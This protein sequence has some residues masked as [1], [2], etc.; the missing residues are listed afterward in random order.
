[1]SRQR[2][3]HTTGWRGALKTWRRNNRERFNR[4]LARVIGSAE[5]TSTPLAEDTRRILVVRL[6][7]RLGNILFLTPMLRSL[8]ATLPAARIDV[9]IQDRAQIKLLES[10]PGIGRVWIQD[11]T[12]FGILRLLRAV[13][14]ERY[15]LAI[16]P[17]SNS[18]SNRLALALA[19]ARQ[20]MGF[21]G[22]DQWV[23]LTHASPRAGSDHQ[24]LK[25]VQLLEGAIR[26]RH[27][28]TF[29]TLAVF[30]D[31][32][33][34]E[35]AEVHWQNALGRYSSGAPVIGFFARATGR[36][37]LP[38]HWWQA[39]VAAIRDRA[40][41]AVLLEILPAAQALPIVPELPHI[42][43]RPLDELSAMLAKLDVFVAADSGPMHLAAASGV[44]VV[45]LFR[46][47]SPKAYA[48]LGRSCISIEGNKLDA[49]DVAD[50]V[51]ARLSHRGSK[52]S[53]RD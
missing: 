16:D 42:A 26:D 24:A 46:A 14:R 52:T 30:P 45:G 39:W 32:A 2:S 51:L 47:T 27:V 41:D 4:L 17:A 43:I 25:S 1:M 21:A 18:A 40:P 38:P 6:N 36:K 10:L 49:G 33:A 3:G 53:A 12:V 31:V 50:A 37:Q 48:P 22:H 7:K 5:P 35:A 13:R 23:S 28:E 19:G 20:R 8:A 9:V 15:D 11:T 34:C 29:D 44:P